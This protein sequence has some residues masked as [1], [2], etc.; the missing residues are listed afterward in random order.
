MICRNKV[1]RKICVIVSVSLVILT[2]SLLSSGQYRTSAVKSPPGRAVF[3]EAHVP[4]SAAMLS[5]VRPTL[6][7]G[8]EDYKGKEYAADLSDPSNIKT[9][10]EYV[11]ELG[12]YVLRTRVGEREIVTPYMMTPDQYNAMITRQEMFGFF[13]DRNSEYFENK[14]KQSFNLFDMN[15]ALG[16]L[17][18]V[19]G[20]GGVRLS[21]QGSVQLSMG[22]K[23]NKTDNPA[24]SLRSRRRTFF[25]LYQ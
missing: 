14:D 11:P 8:Y 21:T 13:H 9:E 1:V 23:S 18:K 3:E 17:E 5:P 7:R 6:P 4:D 19:F 2:I 10:A 25:S 22:I 12:M 24:L 20:P 15:F 16:P